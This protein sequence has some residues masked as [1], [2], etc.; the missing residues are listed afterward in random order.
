MNKQKCTPGV[1]L[2]IGE[3]GVRVGQSGCMETRVPRVSKEHETCIGKTKHVLR[4]PVIGK[5]QRLDLESDLIKALNPKCNI[6]G[7]RLK[8]S[9]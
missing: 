2:V 5:K 7:K 4:I 9:R 8:S 6:Q 1:Y 3:R